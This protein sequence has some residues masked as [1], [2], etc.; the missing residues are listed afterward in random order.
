MYNGYTEPQERIE[1]RKARILAGN[2]RRAVIVSELPS[3]NP[4]LTLDDCLQM[5]LQLQLDRA[6]RLI[7]AMLSAIEG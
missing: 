3:N 4:E 2:P 1:A 6:T 7:T 5:E